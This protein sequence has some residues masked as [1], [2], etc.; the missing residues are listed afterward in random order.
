MAT[1]YYPA[2]VEPTEAEID[3]PARLPLIIDVN[4]LKI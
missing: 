4:F 2:T 1:F 3:I